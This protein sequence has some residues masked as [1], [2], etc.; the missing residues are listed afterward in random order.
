MFAAGQPTCTGGR[1]IKRQW[2]SVRCRL[3]RRTYGEPFNQTSMAAESGS[4]SFGSPRRVARTTHPPCGKCPLR[5]ANLMKP[6]KLT[7]ARI[8]FFDFATPFCFTRPRH[9]SPAALR[10]ALKKEAQALKSNSKMGGSSISFGSLHVRPPWGVHRNSYVFVV[11]LTKSRKLPTLHFHLS[12]TTSTTCSTALF[13]R[14]GSR[15]TLVIAYLGGR[16][17]GVHPPGR[18][19]VALDEQHR[20]VRPRVPQQEG[21]LA[22]HGWQS[23]RSSSAA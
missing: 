17:G 6:R 9:G 10:S 13:L 23:D 11:G 2:R 18:G 22:R 19:V 5:A 16:R 7:H 3:V 15:V 12:S 20:G 8:F 14:N 4:I 21:R 1:S